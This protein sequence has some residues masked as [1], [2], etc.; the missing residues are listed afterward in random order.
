MVDA[1][2]AYYKAISKAGKINKIL[3]CDWLPKQARWRHV[4]HSRLLTVSHKKNLPE[5]IWIFH[6]PHLFGQDDRI[7]ALFVF[8]FFWQGYKT[9]PPPRS[10]NTQKKS[11]PIYPVILT[12]WLVNNPHVSNEKPLKSFWEGRSY[13]QL[14]TTLP[15]SFGEW[16]GG[17]ME[18]EQNVEV[19]QG[20]WLT[21]VQWFLDH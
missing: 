16:K 4:A 15:Q 2:H 11:W 19:F 5:T 21:H 17:V 20:F 6:W 7:V 1:M 10:I 3:N 18:T 9:L 13:C 8:F 14:N 12:S